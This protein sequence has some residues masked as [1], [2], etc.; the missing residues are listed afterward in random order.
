[1]RVR[2]G[3][4]L[5]NKTATQILQ[6]KINN[7]C[8]NDISGNFEKPKGLFFSFNNLQMSGIES[9]GEKKEIA[10]PNGAKYFGD[11]NSK[12]QK[13]GKGIFNDGQGNIYEGEFKNDL[14]EGKGVYKTQEGTVYNGEWSNNLQNG[15]GKETWPD[16]SFYLGKYQKGQKHGEGFYKWEDG[17]E[18]EGEWVDGKAEGHVGL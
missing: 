13:H 6:M 1:V 16:G 17:S 7:D 11:C 15:I 9:H 18:Y 14:I 8:S 10:Y 2:A 4:W 5:A 12:N 3:T